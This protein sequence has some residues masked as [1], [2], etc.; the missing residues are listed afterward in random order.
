MDLLEEGNH[1]CKIP[2]H[3]KSHGPYGFSTFPQRLASVYRG[4]L[5]TLDHYCQVKQENKA[6]SGGKHLQLS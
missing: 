4:C 1:L 5:D 3:N 2:P 6:F